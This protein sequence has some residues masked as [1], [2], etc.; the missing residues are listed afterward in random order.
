MRRSMIEWL[1]SAP[2]TGLGT[3]KIMTEQEL[4]RLKALGYSGGEKV[5]GSL[6]EEDPQSEWVQFFAR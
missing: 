4:Q 6:Y 2:S 5:D 3:T 1:Q